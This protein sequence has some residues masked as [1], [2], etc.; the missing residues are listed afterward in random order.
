MD[1]EKL[2]ELDRIHDERTIEKEKLDRSAKKYASE[3]NELDKLFIYTLLLILN[4]LY[5]KISN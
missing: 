2:K 3:K 4:T 1:I 5:K